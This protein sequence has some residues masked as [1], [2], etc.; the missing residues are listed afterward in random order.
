MQVSGHGGGVLVGGAMHG[1]FPVGIDRVDIQT[2]RNEEFYRFEAFHF[3]ARFFLGSGTSDPRRHHEGGATVFI[4]NE[5]I[6]SQFQ[7]EFHV[8][9][10]ARSAAMKKAVAPIWLTRPLP[11]RLPL[12]KRALD[13]RPAR[14]QFAGELLAVSLARSPRWGSSPDGLADIGF[15]YPGKG[16]KRGIS[17]SSVIGIGA[18]IEQFDGQIIMAVSMAK[19]NGLV[20]LRGPLDVELPKFMAPFTSAPVFEQQR[21][22]VPVPLTY[23]EKERGESRFQG[24]ENRPPLPAEI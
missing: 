15:A 7:E 10:I 20:P 24:G 4:G 14:H 5:R 17:R 16:V 11:A 23:G 19:I 2:Q 8:G 3:R 13:I 18:G 12:V 1:G 22:Y 21:S 6:R 9:K